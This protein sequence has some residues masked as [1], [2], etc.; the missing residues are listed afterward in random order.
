MRHM[1][2]TI[3]DDEIVLTP[4][5]CFALELPVPDHLAGFACCGVRILSDGFLL[6]RDV[7]I[8]ATA[9]ITPTAN[10]PGAT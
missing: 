9:Q 10:F 4:F 6:R 1:A 3:S 5:L 8:D 2:R 7:P